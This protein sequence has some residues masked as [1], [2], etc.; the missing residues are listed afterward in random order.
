MKKNQFY[1]R[2]ESLN[3]NQRLAVDNIDGPLIVVAGPGSGKTELLAL[4]T[5]QIIRKTDVPS[6]SVLCITFTNAATLNM[7]ERLLGLIGS[8]AHKVSIYTFHSFCLE[9][10]ERFKE[11]FPNEEKMI[12]ADDY[13]KLQI[14]EKV[15]EG[16][17]FDDPLKK[18]NKEGGFL[19]L[20][21]IER[22][23][24]YLQEAGVKPE[25]FQK[26]IR[27]NE[28]ELK[29]INKII[30]KYLDKRVSK[31]T[32]LELDAFLSN[33]EYNLSN[34]SDVVLKSLSRAVF[35]GET[36]NISIWKQNMT[37]RVEGK[38]VIKETTQIE[39]LKSL[40]LIYKKY[41]EE[42]KI[43]GYYTFSDMILN[44]IDVLSENE[45]LRKEVQEKYQYI[46]VDEFQDTNGA[47]M[48]LLELLTLNTP[49]DKPN[50]C[51]VGDDDQ[52]I[53]QFQGADI[54]NILDFKEKYKDIKTVVLLKNYRSNQEIVD[55]SKDVIL[56]VEERLEGKYD[57]I[58]K[59]FVA[60][61]KKDGRVIFYS[62]STK[63]EEISFIAEEIKRKIKKDKIKP[64]NIAVISR[65][66]REIKDLLP[67]FVK[68]KV[69]FLA[70]KKENVLEKE[71]IKEIISIIKFS[72]YLFKR[73]YINA[74]FL[75]PEILAYPFFQIEREKIW[76]VAKKSYQERLSW[77]D[78][79]L[80]DDNFSEVGKFFLEV[81]S[82]LGKD[83]IEE[84]LN[85]IIGNK[86]TTFSFNF[87]KFYFENKLDKKE[88]YLNFLFSIKSFLIAIRK[89]YD[90]KI[91]K[92]EDLINFINF[93][94]KN[95]LSILEKGVPNFK[96]NAVSLITAHSA[97]GRE[98]EVVF[99]NNCYHES[100][101]KERGYSKI[102]FP[103]NMP[104]E[105]AGNK[106][107]ERIRLFYVAMTRAKK[108]LYLTTHQE[109]SGNK[110]TVLLDFLPDIKKEEK[111]QKIIVDG[112]EESLFGK[113]ENIFS[114]SEKETLL[115]LVK[116]YKLSATGF[117]KFLN[118]VNG[119]PKV[120]F[121]DHILRFP[122]QKTIYSSYGTAFHGLIKEI[123]FIL[124]K[125]DRIVSEKEAFQIFKEIIEKERLS[126]KDH[127]HS[128]RKGKKEVS[129]FYKNK[130]KD[131]RKEDIIEK[132]FKNEGCTVEN[133]PISGKVDKM[134]I[135]SSFI[136]VFD[137][138]TGEPIFTL[139]EKEE[140]K[141][142][143]GWQ[144][145]NQLIF[146][147]L[148]IEN[149]RDFS[150]YKVDCGFLDFVSTKKNNI[151][152]VKIERE[153]TERV[154]KLIK[155]IYKKISNVDFVSIDRYQR[156]TL[157]D[158]KKFENDLLEEK[159]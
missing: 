126:E 45:D 46:Q 38:L 111:C 129:Y 47:Q 67:Y 133:V 118:I 70:E 89:H 88:G 61:K 139:N 27:E 141:K 92:K 112:F 37:R 58:R 96:E 98:F 84:A 9:I 36:K 150:K 57:D 40:S 3:K 41:M 103:L 63:E 74:D 64:K 119:G 59:N 116:D 25:E 155:I 146:Y 8:E 10:T 33:K 60:E 157:K 90:K 102:S 5:A 122:Q 101:G 109:R 18:I 76:E 78:C 55:K 44:V 143:R 148:L 15:L 32:F 125:E 49:E 20:R 117:N 121:E 145:K 51:V 77:I 81:A 19:Y 104:I 80:K 42:I 11:Y 22:S 94:E 2:Y 12:V 151:L 131:F 115:S 24:F 147:K 120:F 73:D 54:S 95:D 75:L 23:I 56:N 99:V 130:V 7:R 1:K 79:F 21:D 17:E 28:K 26:K 65:T 158:I 149:S 140:R 107:D 113:K 34:L 31:K 144:Y 13:V 50:I 30:D 127:L 91:I 71:P 110:K 35:T 4:R 142:I 93:Y 85:L 97:K 128:L 106:R 137:Y 66:H 52:A 16:L 138:K 159:I 123:Y 86:K 108:E 43:S 72:F 53:Y 136:D 134:R 39:K 152:E 153:D 48:R 62:F 124:S 100:W 156:K 83:A 82:L 14:I 68:S 135:R 105:R 132:D 87:K 154:K 6:S 29:T 69:P 114:S